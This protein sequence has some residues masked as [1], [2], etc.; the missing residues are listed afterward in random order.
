MQ[1]LFRELRRRNIPLNQTDALE[2]F[3]GDGTRHTVDYHRLVHSLDVWEINA[4]LSAS[5]R[6]NLPGA[7]ITIAD[8]FRELQTSGNTYDLIVIDTPAS[9]FGT[10]K[11]YC[12][13]FE[14]FTPSLF[15]IARTSA[16]M[17]MNVVPNLQQSK[18]AWRAPAS[19]EQLSKRS[20]FYKTDRPELVPVDEMVPVYR[21]IADAAGFELQWHFSICRTLRSQVHYLAVK[22]GRR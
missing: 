9:L 13:H 22:V 11:Q 12:E 14:I 17:I 2:M 7:G 5:L 10:E 16:V 8:S 3:G 4:G 20:T 6:Q 21:Q 18:N 15:R 1:S 19:P